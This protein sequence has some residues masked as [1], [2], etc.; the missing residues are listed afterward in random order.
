[1]KHEDG[2]IDS[3][4]RAHVGSELEPAQLEQLYW[5][6]DPPRHV[7]RTRFSRGAIR[8]RSVTRDRAG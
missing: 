1:M 8:A 4:Q 6:A 7:G 5:D 2:T 3:F